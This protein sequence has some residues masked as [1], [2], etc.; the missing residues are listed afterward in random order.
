MGLIFNNINESNSCIHIWHAKESLKELESL[1]LKRSGNTSFPEE[2]FKNKLAKRKKHWLATRLI[3]QEI[4]HDEIALVHDQFGAPMLPSNDVNISISHSNTMVCVI[5]SP[6]QQVGIDIQILSPKLANIS[7]KFLSSKENEIYI[8]TQ[9]ADFLHT[10]WTSKE[11][12]FK[13]F[14]SE[15]PFKDIVLASP[16]PSASG[17][18]EF[19]VQRARKN[20]IIPVQTH[21]SE[22]YFL[23]YVKL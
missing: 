1:Y 13:A 20:F 17:L 2:F 10:L 23:S 22:D 5:V 15:L 19:H 8:R 3:L 7:S 9:S 21:K 16:Y 11:A 4:F 12:I 14:R 6:F 18:L